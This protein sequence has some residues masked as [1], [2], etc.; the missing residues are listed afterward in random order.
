MRKSLLFLCLI[1]ASITTLFAVD[2]TVAG[3]EKYKLLFGAGLNYNNRDGFKDYPQNT[4]KFDFT[5]PVSE[6]I[7]L[8][9]EGSFN[10]VLEAYDSSEP[11]LVDFNYW[12]ALNNYF[13]VALGVVVIPSKVK[14]G[15]YAMGGTENFAFR[16][17]NNLPDGSSVLHMK[18]NG[19]FEM[20]AGMFLLEGLFN[21]RI[22]KIDIK[23]GF[24]V[25][26]NGFG[27]SG[28]INNFSFLDEAN[29]G[30]ATTDNDSAYS[31]ASA[32][33]RFNGWEYFGEL[34]FT[35]PVH[36]LAGL[37]GLD[38][39]KAGAVLEYK[40]SG[41]AYSEVETGGIR[42]YTDLPTRTKAELGLDNWLKIVPSSSI[43]F[44]LA[45]K[46]GFEYSSYKY[47]YDRAQTTTISK[48]NLTL[49]T[50]FFMSGKKSID[51]AGRWGIVPF[52]ELDIKFRLE[53]MQKLTD[54][55]IESRALY[56]FNS[57]GI[58]VD[59]GVKLGLKFGTWETAI[60]WNPQVSYN[61]VADSAPAQDDA[62]VVQ[63][64]NIWNLA[65]WQ[66]TIDC[67]FYPPKQ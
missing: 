61:I 50:E 18:G 32:L 47:K 53:F 14:I 52:F 23:Q 28:T 5:L 25:L 16:Q 26:F 15:L 66:F 43:S 64:S 37:K 12:S 22:E 39:L 7:Q 13:K 60:V 11:N 3:A 17:Y 51:L 34:G 58:S 49:F 30:D 63:A 55:E 62:V 56:T 38:S 24:R 9:L 21:N 59:P 1:T 41:A 19:F 29:D 54:N 40:L 44:K 65:N 10:N 27:Y 20:K 6:T 57:G 48:E 45:I 35:I 2:E 33:A 31:G 36:T 4:F 42:V 8:G 46:P 67:E